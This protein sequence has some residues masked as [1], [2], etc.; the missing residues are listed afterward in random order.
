V[1]ERREELTTE[2]GLDVVGQRDRVRDALSRFHDSGIEVSLFIDPDPK[3][4]EAAVA[5][6]AVAVEFHTGRYANARQGPDR[7]RELD[8]LQAAAVT[9]VTSGL[10]LHAGHGLNYQNVAPVARL[11]RM[12]ELNIGHSIISRAVFVGMTPAVRE[13]KECID[14]SL[15]REVSPRG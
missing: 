13:M 9:A 5:L 3:Q 10:K 14:R 6:G 7:T 12:A 11:D 1:P 8:A 15:G 4:V 2:G